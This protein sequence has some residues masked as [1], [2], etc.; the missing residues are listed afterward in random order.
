MYCLVLEIPYTSTE[1]A[2][3]TNQK[4]L[5]NMAEGVINQ[6]LECIPVPQILYLKRGHLLGHL[7]LE[8]I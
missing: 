5:K 6:P 4:P 7:F 8:I 2:Q 3:S 1:L